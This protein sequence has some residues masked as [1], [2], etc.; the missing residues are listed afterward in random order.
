MIFLKKKS[1]SFFALII[2]ALAFSFSV[3]A[4][5]DNNACKKVYRDGA[6]DLLEMVEDYN[7]KSLTKG[8]FS[9]EV[10]A[11]GATV[12]TLRTACFFVES[13]EVGDCVDSYKKIYKDI[14][15]HI[16]LRAIM[17]GNQDKVKLP[18]GFKIKMIGKVAIQDTVC[19]IQ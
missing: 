10:T 4:E 1:T 15:G 17:A 6:L 8:Q 14:R 7:G 13:P 5:L 3:Q 9:T 2:T 19:K 18:F 11:I 12:K 16:R